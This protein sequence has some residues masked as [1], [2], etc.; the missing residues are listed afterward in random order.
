[1][2]GMVRE[3]WQSRWDFLLAAVGSAVGLGNMW[4]FSY[5]TA[6]K[7]G[8]GFVGLYMLFTLLIGLPVMLAEMTIGRGARM[9]PVAALAHFG[10]PAWR[11]LGIVFVAAGF[12]ILSYYGVI[13]GWTIDS[14]R[15][16]ENW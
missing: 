11:W 2:A 7:G 3:Q 10:G 6:E 5:L 9:G 8:A 1:M 16:R 12:L 13:R 4:R 14:G 15:R